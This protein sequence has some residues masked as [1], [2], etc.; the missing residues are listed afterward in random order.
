MKSG[1][2]QMEILALKNSPITPITTAFAFAKNIAGTED[3]QSEQAMSSSF[4]LEQQW[5]TTRLSFA[6]ASSKS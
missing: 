6:K 4:S 3:P 5:L 2:Q 1:Q